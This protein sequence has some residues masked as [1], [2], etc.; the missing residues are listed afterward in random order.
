LL[1]GDFNALEGEPAVA[2]ARVHLKD[3]FRNRHPSSP[4]TTWS[5]ANP[6]TRGLDDPDRRLDY[7]FCPTDAFVREAFVVLDRPDPDYSS[8]HFGVC[9]AVEFGPLFNS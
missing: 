4:G 7:V 5:R 9:V 2:H 3:C 1:A 8:D 6:L